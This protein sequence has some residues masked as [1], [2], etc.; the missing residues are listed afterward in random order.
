MKIG[1]KSSNWLSK[2]FSIDR[3]RID[4]QVY[5]MIPS[6]KENSVSFFEV[7][8][9]FALTVFTALPPKE[10]QKVKQCQGF[11]VLLD[12]QKV[13]AGRGSSNIKN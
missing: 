7:K 12:G 4:L 3:D 11:C 1:I 13:G 10:A 8:Y 9:H 5:R 6:L 2:L